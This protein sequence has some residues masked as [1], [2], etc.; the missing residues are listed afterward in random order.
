M[1]QRINNALAELEDIAEM[2]DQLKISGELETAADISEA[3][4][5]AVRFH[6][7]NAIDEFHEGIE[8][9]EYN[10]QRADHK[11]ENRSKSGGKAY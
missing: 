6:I 1:K 5:N 4:V 7:E 11:P 10:A 3:E 8:K 9:M 2:M